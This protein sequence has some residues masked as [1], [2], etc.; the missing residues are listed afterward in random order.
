MEWWVYTL[1]DYATTFDFSKSAKQIGLPLESLITD[2]YRLDQI[3]EA[4]QANMAMKGIKI[5]I[6][7]QS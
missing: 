4:M 1:R 6:I 5:A 7:N 3:D 2:T